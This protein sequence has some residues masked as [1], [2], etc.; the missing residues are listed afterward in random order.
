MGCK[1]P[2]QEFSIQWD[3]FHLELG[4]N[5]CIMGILNLT[6]DSFSD[7]GNFFSPEDGIAQ[8]KKLAAQGADILD[9]GGESTRPFSQ[10]IPPEE[11]MARVLPVIKALSAEL[12]IPISIDTWKSEVARAALDAGASM[13]N[14]ISAF[15]DD[16][17]MADLA[18]ERQVPVV[19]MHKKGTPE[20]MQKA[21]SYGDL[22]SEIVNYLQDRAKFAI[23]KGIKKEHIILD[24][25]IGFGKTLAHNLSLMNHVE[26]LS[27][28]GFPVLMASSRKSCIRQVLEQNMEAPLTADHE[29]MEYGTL[30]TLAASISG[31]AHIVRVHDVYKAKA[32]TRMLDAIHNAV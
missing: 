24:P 7:G 19:L 22:I 12:A 5:T 31:G 32:F 17:A 8:G 25:G 4:Q 13:I 29:I 6:P 15:E 21:P 2:R 30:A 10:Y 3:R 9:I 18:A 1:I 16:P 27:A 20:T 11:E 28:S 23:T 26:A 14:D